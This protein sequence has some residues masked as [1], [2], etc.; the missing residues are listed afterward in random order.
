MV[1]DRGRGAGG[2]RGVE[3]AA[4]RRRAA[5]G[6]GER[7]HGAPARPCAGSGDHGR[8]RRRQLRHGREPRAAL[9]G[10]R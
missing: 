2:G 10:R 3:R 1:G 6:G 9:V 4:R 7:L 5:G 8:A